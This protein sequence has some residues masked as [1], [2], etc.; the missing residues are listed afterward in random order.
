MINDFKTCITGINTFLF[1][2]NVE[3]NKNVDDKSLWMLNKHYRCWSVK[4]SLTSIMRMLQKTDII[5]S[6]FHENVKIN[7]IMATNT[8]SMAINFYLFRSFR[9]SIIIVIILFYFIQVKYRS[10]IKVLPYT[11]RASQWNTFNGFW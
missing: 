11:A 7:F 10:Q 6:F 8:Y 3:S 4:N 1:V 9:I 5:L 2:S